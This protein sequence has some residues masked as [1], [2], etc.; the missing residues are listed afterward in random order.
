MDIPRGAVHVAAQVELQSDAAT[1]QSADGGDFVDGGDLG[2]MPLQGGCQRRRHC[3]WIGAGQGGGAGNHRVID[4][5]NRG[6]GHEPVSGRAHREQTEGEK[7]RGHR[8]VDEGRGDVHDVRASGLRECFSTQGG[9]GGHG[10]GE[11]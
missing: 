5:G 3:G 4:S 10:F 2:Q 7:G 6:D 8:P 9:G 1:A 11:T